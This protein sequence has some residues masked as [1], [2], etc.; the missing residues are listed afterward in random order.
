[1][2]NNSRTTVV[3]IIL[4]LV[5]AAAVVYLLFF[6]TDPSAA[7]VAELQPV[8]AAEVTFINL[9][10]QIEP[11]TFNTGILSDP[12][13]MALEDISTAI[14]PEVPGR[15]DPFGPVSGVSGGAN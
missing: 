2:E 10:T 3:L 1:M 5:I 15:N 14:L 9:V 4:G 13:F 12:R 7:L 8:G 6:R 11:I